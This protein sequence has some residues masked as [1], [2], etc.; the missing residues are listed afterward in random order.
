MFGKRKHNLGMCFKL[1]Y[2]YYIYDDCFISSS[3]HENRK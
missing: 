3:V 2:V 1:L